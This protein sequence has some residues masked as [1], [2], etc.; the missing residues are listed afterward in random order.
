MA[1]ASG[2][3]VCTTIRDMYSG[4]GILIPNNQRKS[5]EIYSG[6]KFFC[7]VVGAESPDVVVKSDAAQEITNA[8]RDLG[9]HA[10]TSVAHV[11]PHNTVHERWHLTAQKQHQMPDVSIWI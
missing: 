7:G 8:V 4:T 3:N 1:S 5:D 9:W 11:W 2:N 6:L 10:D